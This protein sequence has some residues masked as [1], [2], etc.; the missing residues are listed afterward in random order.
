MHRRLWFSVAMLAAGASLLVAASFASASSSSP[1]IHNGGTL[2]IG[3]TGNLD[4]VDP[5]IAYGTTSWW[6]EF[7]TRANLYTYPDKSGAAGGKLVPE[8][9]KGFTVS[10]NGRCTRST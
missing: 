3:G 10:K 2:K 8:V 4:S 5:Q 9:A 1:S 7:A 6:F